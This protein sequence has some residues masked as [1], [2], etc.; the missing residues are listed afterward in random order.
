MPRR[1]S[2][3]YTNRQING[4]VLI[5]IGW[6]VVLI[7]CCGT[8]SNAIESDN[9]P[10]KID[11]THQTT[12]PTTEPATTTPATTEPAA[13]TTTAKKQNN[14]AQGGNNYDPDPDTDIP[15]VHPGSFCSPRGALGRTSAG[16]L[17]RCQPGSDGRNRWSRA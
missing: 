8:I 11:V 14:P 2:R 5:T 13:P 1:I 17:M 6:I 9:K 7:C 10:P 16:T 3:R 12:P 15:T 4:A